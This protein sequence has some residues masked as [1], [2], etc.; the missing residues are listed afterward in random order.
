MVFSGYV[1]EQG[2]PI[3]TGGRYDGLCGQFGPA[4]PAAGFA[5]DMQAAAGLIQGQLPPEEASQVLVH[6]EPGFEMKAQQELIR[7]TEQGLACESSVWESLEEA[8][9][10]A[11]QAGIPRLLAVGESVREI[12]PGEEERP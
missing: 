1:R 12:Q 4:M 7:L 3:L 9:A 8:R 11:E 2:R 10:Y 6:G 5:V